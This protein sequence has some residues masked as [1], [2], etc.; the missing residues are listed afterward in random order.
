MQYRPS[1]D[2]MSVTN[3]A[4]PD[5]EASPSII[6]QT[7]KPDALSIEIDQTSSVSNDRESHNSS[8]IDGTLEDGNLSMGN[9]WIEN[10]SLFTLHFEDMTEAIDQMY[11][12]ASQIRN[13]KARRI[14]TDID[15]FNEV[16]D[17]IKS[18]YIKLRTTAESRGIEQ[19]LLQSRKSLLESQAKNIEFILTDEHRCLIL[20]LQKANHARRQQFEY[21]KRSKKRSIRAASK[22]IGTIPTSKDS[23]RRLEKVLK[24]DTGSLV[25]PSEITR[26]LMSSVPALSKKFVLSDK[27]STYLGASRGLTVHGPSGGKVDWPKPPVTDPSGGD[28]EC[29]FCFYFCAPRYWEDVAWRFVFYINMLRQVVD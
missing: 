21:W 2:M 14:R 12:L 18:E 24:H 7:P 29:P 6:A 4:N 13:P 8:I 5:N 10:E 15:L 1:N 22:A 23:D 16:D 26:S 20:R 11:N 19:M 25:Q 28:F 17:D 9:E 3:I 27:K